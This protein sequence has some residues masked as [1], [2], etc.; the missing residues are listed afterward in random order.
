MLY[1]IRK[2]I[3]LIIGNVLLIFTGTVHLATQVF[4]K[5]TAENAEQETLID[6]YQRI[7]FSMPDKS[8]RTLE[9]VSDGYS[10]YAALLMIASGLFL[11]LYPAGSRAEANAAKLA[12]ILCILLIY[13]TYSLLIFPPLV[14]LL[15]SLICYLI[16]LA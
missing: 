1:Q 3:S 8:Q 4:G 6:L 12:C 11:S 13:V 15:L 14:L 5:L 16:Y 2:R 9:N 7:T 10:F